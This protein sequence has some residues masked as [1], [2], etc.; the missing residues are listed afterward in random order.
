MPRLEEIEHGLLD[1]RH[2]AQKHATSFW[3][4]FKVSLL[5]IF[6]QATAEKNRTT[7]Y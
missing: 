3:A 7:A 5:V 4:D 6:C 2:T 1:S